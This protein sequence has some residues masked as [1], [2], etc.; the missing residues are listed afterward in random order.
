MKIYY[1]RSVTLVKYSIGIDIGGTK[2]ATA[3][4]KESG[5]MI[6]QE[7]YKTPRKNREAIIQL[8]K[9]RILSYIH[10]AETEQFELIGI[11]IGS[12]GQIDYENGHILS[13]TDNIKDWNNVPIKTELEKV[14]HLPI[15]VDNDANTFA[16]AEHQLGQ[17]AN[18]DD[19]V[20]LTLGTG[21]GGGVISGGRILHG[22][23]GG[24]AELGHMTVDVNGP[25][26]NCGS[27][28]CIETYASGTG[29]ANR[30]KARVNE[31]PENKLEPYMSRPE[32]ITS[33]EVFAWADEG[34]SLAVTI[35]DDAIEKLSYG[36][37]NLIH[38]FNP[39]LI[40]LGGGLVEGRDWLAQRLESK[41]QNRGITSLVESTPIVV[42]KLGSD[43][44]LIGAAQQV[45]LNRNP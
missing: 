40:I 14:T 8:L 31:Q 11:G 12:A 28:G 35:I 34:I 15:F 42:S 22:A 9:D 3:L 24:A 16:I 19:I 25:A 36:I 27:R 1:L 45:W 43:N 23:W 37:I 21:I 39:R 30:M 10:L 7:T 5:H 41:I 26:C 32:D 33:K 17:G 44:G 20:C 6:H 13:G 18:K 4:V 29:I 38:I 2:I